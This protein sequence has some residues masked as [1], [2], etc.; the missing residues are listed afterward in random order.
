MEKAVKEGTGD[1]LSE[2]GGGGGVDE[3]A[4]KL[5]EV[6]VT[7]RGHEVK[8]V[9]SMEWGW[10]RMQC[11]REVEPLDDKGGFRKRMGKRGKGG[12]REKERGD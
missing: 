12:G 10:E 8:Q 3:C 2:N 11:G 9:E 6:W 5:L 4:E 1:V 7:K